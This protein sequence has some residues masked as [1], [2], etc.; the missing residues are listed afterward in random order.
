MQVITAGIV[1][2]YI[3]RDGRPRQVSII[4]GVAR[5]HVAISD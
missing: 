2:A 3:T 4:Y 5:L 1:I